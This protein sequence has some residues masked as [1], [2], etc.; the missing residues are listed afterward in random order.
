MLNMD[1]VRSSFKSVE[2]SLKSH[3]EYKALYEFQTVEGEF[4]RLAEENK[5]LKIMLTDMGVDYVQVC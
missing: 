2:T 1:L 5:K 4:L 3:C